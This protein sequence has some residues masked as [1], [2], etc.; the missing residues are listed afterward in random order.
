MLAH[1]L[2]VFESVQV[3]PHD[4]DAFTGSLSS[5][6]QPTLFIDDFMHEIQS[7]DAGEL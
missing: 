2:A 6:Q 1:A 7:V 5:Q 3:Q 4:H